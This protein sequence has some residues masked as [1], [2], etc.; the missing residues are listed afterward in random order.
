MSNQTLSTAAASGAVQVTQ[1][2]E[3]DEFHSYCLPNNVLI[4]L[5]EEAEEELGL[6]DD[7]SRSP[8][9]EAPPSLT[10]MVDDDYHATTTTSQQDAA[11]RKRLISHMLQMRANW[12]DMYPK[13]LL[14]K[15]YH[16]VEC[17][18]K[19]FSSLLR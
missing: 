4:K 5:L 3:E 13:N 19:R 17:S 10:Q 12:N 1:E 2:D 8:S 9:P 6:N 15:H 18:I 7:S 11:E 14:V 16:R